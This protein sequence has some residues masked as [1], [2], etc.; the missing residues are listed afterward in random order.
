VHSRNI[1]D[2][3]VTT[4]KIDDEAV[5]LA[6]QA[7][8]TARTVIGNVTGAAATPTAVAI[9]DDDTLATGTTNN[10]ATAESIKAYVD[11]GYAYNPTNLTNEGYTILPNG[12]IMQWGTETCADSVPEAITLPTPFTT[13]FLSAQATQEDPALDGVVFAQK[14]S[15]TNITIGVDH[16]S[17]STDVDWFA[18]GY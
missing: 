16:T 3:D 8:L 6:K 5:T 13:T 15:L 1:L 12:L 4:A 18:V 7:D 10:L 9:I 2:G 11:G 17:G 14:T